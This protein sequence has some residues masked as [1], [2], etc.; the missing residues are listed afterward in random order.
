MLVLIDEYDT[1]NNF[2]Y[3]RGYFNE[4]RSLSLPL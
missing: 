1:P 3:E 2:A 4:V